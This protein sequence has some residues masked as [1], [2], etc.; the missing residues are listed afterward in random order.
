MT[1]VKMT[2]AAT[3]IFVGDTMI[4]VKMMSGN[5]GDGRHHDDHREDDI[6]AATM[7]TAA[8]SDVSLVVRHG[9]LPRRSRVSEG[10]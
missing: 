2:V 3:M 7:I 9:R 1:I 10:N 8:Y 5:D 6:M 4:V